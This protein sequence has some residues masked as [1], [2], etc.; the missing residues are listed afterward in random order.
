MQASSPRDHKVLSST[1]TY[2]LPPPT[3]LHHTYLALSLRCTPPSSLL[4]LIVDRVCARWPRGSSVMRI[5][6][7]ATLKPSHC[8]WDS[9]VVIFCICMCE[10]VYVPCKMISYAALDCWVSYVSECI[11]KLRPN[12][13]CRICVCVVC[14]TS[15]RT[16]LRRTNTF[17]SASSRYIHHL[18]HPTIHSS[19]DPTR[20]SSPRQMPCR[21]LSTFLWA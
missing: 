20:T 4:C 13:A 18:P 8:R 15:L 14:R 9:V 10:S 19:A 6:R 3:L 12:P 11:E 7:S 17:P 5:W 2:V 16:S 1:T 21:F